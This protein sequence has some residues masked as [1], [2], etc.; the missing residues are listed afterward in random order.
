MTRYAL[1]FSPTGGTKKVAELLTAAWPEAVES[2]DLTAKGLD[3]AQMGF[4][5]EDV[6]LIAVPSYGGRVPALAAE[7]L[8][9][10]K[11]GGARAVLLGVY[12]NRA[13]EDTLLE[14]EDMVREE[15]FLPVAAVAA[16][17]QHS[18]LPQFGSGRPDEQDRLEL[19]AFAAHIAQL[20]AQT[21]STEALKVP[22]N[23][24]YRQYSGVPLRPQAGKGC[25]R[26]GLCAAQCPVGAIKP[27]NPQATD[28]KRCISCMRCLTV[29]P[30]KARKL[31]KMMTF[32]A[33]RKM[34]KACSSR[35][36]N[37]LFL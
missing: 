18:M 28:A 27:D 21:P 7:R 8:A 33:A 23:R 36:A 34:K 24:P 9:M 1:V 30:Q 26:C 5:P 10:L 17:A 13:Y 22:G 14:L 35:K 3:F 20:L 12:G 25:T 16:V 37:A 15:G 2:I 6:C 29:C 19:A 11:G 32:A 4:G 31:N